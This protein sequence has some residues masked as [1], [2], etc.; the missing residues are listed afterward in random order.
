[1]LDQF[2][3]AFAPQP[4]FTRATSVQK[5]LTLNVDAPILEAVYLTL[6]FRFVPAMESDIARES[7]SFRCRTPANYRRGL[8]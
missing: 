2:I 1:M 3:A 8:R 4:K 7:E 5:S 6:L